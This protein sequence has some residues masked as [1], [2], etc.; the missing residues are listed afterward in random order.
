MEKLF[1]YRFSW[2]K[3]LEGHSFGNLFIAAMADIT[4]DFEES[5]REF[6]KVLAVRG[7]VVPSTLQTVKLRAHYNDGSEIVGESQIPQPGKE[8]ERVCLEPAEVF[9]VPEAIEAIHNADIVVLGPGSLYTS[10]IPNVLVSPIADTLVSSAA[11]KVYVCNVMTQPGETDN[12]SASDHAKAIIEHC[13]GKRVIDHVIMNNA[14]ISPL[15]SQKY[16]EQNAYPIQ[17]DRERLH[18][19]GLRVTTTPLLDEQDLV[20]HDSEKLAREI[21]RLCLEHKPNAMWGIRMGMR[22]DN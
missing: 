19:M 17:A 11:L 3:G 9:A 2:G 21:M 8:I 1:Q 15:Q 5:I 7:K 4:G 12:M 16:R 10:I 20:R 14:R 22:G 18:R 6:S 13:D